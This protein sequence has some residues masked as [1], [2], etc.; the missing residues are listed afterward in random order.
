MWLI[1][2][3]THIKTKQYS[4]FITWY[5]KVIS[6]LLIASLYLLEYSLNSFVSSEKRGRP[7]W[8][9]V[10]FSCFK[11]YVIFW[12]VTKTL[13]LSSLYHLELFNLRIAFFSSWII[14]HHSFWISV[15]FSLGVV[16]PLKI[17]T[18]TS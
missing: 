17:Y 15:P 12:K 7:W 1:S 18:V 8:L 16:K 6:Y 5:F 14:F 9:I 3:S 10:F 4:E 11:F 2:S 13:N